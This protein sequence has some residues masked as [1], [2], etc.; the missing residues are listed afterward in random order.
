MSIGAI[1]IGEK[2]QKNQM[3]KL[4]T[5]VEDCFSVVKDKQM[6]TITGLLWLVIIYNQNKLKIFVQIFGRIK[7][8]RT[9]VK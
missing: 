4:L 6:A 8:M 7:I 1:L 3:A 5:V 2:S 9:F